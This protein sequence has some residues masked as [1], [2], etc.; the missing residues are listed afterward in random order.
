MLHIDLRSLHISHKITH[1]SPLA[2]KT[3][4]SLVSM[5]LPSFIAAICSG[6]ITIPITVI[7][8]SH[9]PHPT[10]VPSKLAHQSCCLVLETDC[11]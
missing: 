2:F 1:S 8:E 11:F 4:R 9:L 7:P 6:L 3:F 10:S 5:F